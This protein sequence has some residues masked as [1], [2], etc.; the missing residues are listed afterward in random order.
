MSGFIPLL[1]VP[2]VSRIMAGT[3]NYC[4]IGKYYN[5]QIDYCF[6]HGSKVEAGKRLTVLRS[7]DSNCVLFSNETINPCIVWKFIIYEEE[8]KYNSYNQIDLYKKIKD[9]E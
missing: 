9:S 4:N 6:E 3:A 8:N 2:L 7:P 1:T 5:G